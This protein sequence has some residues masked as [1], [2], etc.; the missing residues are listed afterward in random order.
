MESRGEWPASSGAVLAARRSGCRAGT[1]SKA[2][3]DPAAELPGAHECL[4]KSLPFSVLFVIR[5]QCGAL[6]G[7]FRQ[8]R[9]GRVILARLG[10]RRRP[11]LA[12][13]VQGFH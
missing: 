6:P 13:G 11:T 9:I 7:Q 12:Q 5:H 1:Y 2:V 8:R 4:P 3:S 10:I